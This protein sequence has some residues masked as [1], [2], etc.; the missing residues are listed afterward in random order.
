[1]D[2]LCGHEISFWPILNIQTPKP[3][4]VIYALCGYKNFFWPILEK[5]VEK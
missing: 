5:L 2:V 4:V 1:M 3:T